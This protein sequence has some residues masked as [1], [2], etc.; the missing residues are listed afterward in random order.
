MRS[1]CG[2]K[3]VW[4]SS[5]KTLTWEKVCDGRSFHH[6]KVL[7]DEENKLEKFGE[8]KFAAEKSWVREIKSRLHEKDLK[9]FSR[10]RK[11]VTEKF[12][13]AENFSRKPTNQQIKF[14]SERF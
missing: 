3:F 13:P 6:Q 5:P 4:N 1:L 2:E 12:Q 7:G 14:S 8:G 9:K 10:R 11:F